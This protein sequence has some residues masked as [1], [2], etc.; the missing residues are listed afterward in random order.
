MRALIYIKARLGGGSHAVIVQEGL[1]ALDFWHDSF[2]V[3][4]EDE[5]ALTRSNWMVPMFVF[6][7]ANGSDAPTV[8]L[9]SAWSHRGVASNAGIKMLAPLDACAYWAAEAAA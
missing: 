1:G 7:V 9:V 4:A 8:I 5:R 2:H 6:F 3:Y